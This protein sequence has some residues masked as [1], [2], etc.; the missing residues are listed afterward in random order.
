MREE[1]A[2]PTGVPHTTPAMTGDAPPGNWT[3]RQPSVII[4]DE[5]QVELE[6]RADLTTMDTEFIHAFIH[7]LLSLALSSSNYSSNSSFILYFFLL[8]DL[9]HETLL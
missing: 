6:T 3:S 8:S 5:I 2:I 4:V 7:P 1:R 9:L